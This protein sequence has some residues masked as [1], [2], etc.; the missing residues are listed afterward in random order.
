[1]SPRLTPPKDFAKKMGEDPSLA[2]DMLE[3]KASNLL[4][5]AGYSENGKVQRSLISKILEDEWNAGHELTIE[6]LIEL[7]SNPP[8]EKLG[9]L[10]LDDAIS[11][12][13][14]SELSRR[15]NVLVTD[16]AAR[17]WFLG[18]PPD[19]DRWFHKSRAEPR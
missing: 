12:R 10:P 2:F 8:F 9:M 17:A 16:A 19:F 6:K 13:E 3:L 4:R 1:M 14:R 18:E 7:V 15:L 11:K 5:L